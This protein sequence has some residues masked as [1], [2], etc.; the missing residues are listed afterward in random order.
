M[1]TSDLDDEIRSNDQDFDGYICVKVAW[2]KIWW[3][4]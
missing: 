2:Q 1:S 3:P 4:S